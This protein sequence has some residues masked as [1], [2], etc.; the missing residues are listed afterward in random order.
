MIAIESKQL[1][2]KHRFQI[3][4]IIVCII[5]IVFV[6]Y[7]FL[8]TSI[9][10]N[11][12][13]ANFN[14]PSLK[15][16]NSNTI[17]SKKINTILLNDS[18]RKESSQTVPNSITK[19]KI[20][21]KK[22]KGKIK[23][24]PKPSF[25]ESKKN[26]V[27]EIKRNIISYLYPLS[28]AV[29]VNELPP[30][31][32]GMINVTDNKMGYTIQS[33]NTN[34]KVISI[35][36][37]KEEIPDG[38]TI[39]DVH[40]YF[41]S[42]A[43]KHWN[44][45]KRDSLD[46]ANNIVYSTN[47]E[48]G[49]YINAIIKAPES[50][51][52]QGYTPTSMNDIKV[53]DPASMIQ[54][55]QP[56]IQNNH[57][58]ANISFHIETPKGR[59]GIEPNLDLLY[60]S[61]GGNGI[62]GEGWNLGGI[63]TITVETR[64]GVPQY[65][66][67]FETETYSLDG[68]MLAMADANDNLTMSHRTLNIARINGT[69]RFYCRR[70]SDFSKI[71]RLG[72]LNN[73]IWVVTDKN[74]IKYYYG[75]TTSSGNG[76]VVDAVL[77]EGNKIAEW[78]LRKVEDL[79]QN[80]I[81]YFYDA[82]EENINGNFIKTN[83]LSKIQY[84]FYQNSKHLKN[85]Y[86]LN[87]KYDENVERRKD[88]T[89]NA[90]YGFL[91]SG[92][93][94]LLD[95]IKVSS[96]NYGSD[97]ELE[98]APLEIRKYSFNYSYGSYNKIILDSIRQF[99]YAGNTEQ[100]F[101][102]QKFNY[103][104]IDSLKGK[105]FTD[106]NVPIPSKSFLGESITK[107]KLGFGGAVGIGLPDFQ[108]YSKSLSVDAQ[109]SYKENESETQVSFI[110]V[111]GDNKPDIVRK[112]AGA[113]IYQPNM[114]SFDK[115]SFGAEQPIIGLNSFSKDDGSSYGAGV[116]INGPTQSRVYGGYDQNKTNSYSKY[117]FTDANGDG[118]I[119]VVDNGEVRF[120]TYKGQSSQIEFQKSSANTKSPITTG[121]A[122]GNSLV[123][124]D[125]GRIA[126]EL[127][128]NITI[129]P[130]HDIAKVWIAPDTGTIKIEAPV[131][132]VQPVILPENQEDSIRFKKADGVWVS[133][134][135]NNGNIINP[136]K[137][138][139]NDFS[140]KPINN[141]TTRVNQGDKILFRVQS[142]N[143]E[144]D[145]G[146]F[147]QVV[148]NPTITYTSK[149]SDRHFI[150][151]FDK[152]Q[153]DFNALTDYLNTNGTFN[154]P[155]SGN[156]TILG[157][158]IKPKTKD[159]ITLKIR[160]NGTKVRDSFPDQL[161]VKREASADTVIN[162]MNYRYSSFDS[163][164]SRTL[165]TSKQ[166]LSTNFLVP[167]NYLYN[168]T[169]FFEITPAS[170]FNL[171]EIKWEPKI[172]YNHYDT[173]ETDI[174]KRWKKDS[175]ICSP[176]INFKGRLI[177]PG[178][179]I[180]VKDSGEVKI[181]PVVTLRS[182][183]NAKVNLII[184]DKDKIIIKK[185]ISKST[186]LKDTIS[187]ARDKNDFFTVSYE[188]ESIN[189]IDTSIVSGKTPSYLLIPNDFK[190]WVVP[191]TGIYNFYSIQ[192]GALAKSILQKNGI[193]SLPH[194]RDTLENVFL[195]ENDIISFIDTINRINIMPFSTIMTQA[196]AIFSNWEI[197]DYGSLYRGWGQGVFNASNHLK[198]PIDISLF[199]LEQIQK[200]NFY[201][202][203]FFSMPQNGKNLHYTGINEKVFINRDTMSS[204]RLAMANVNPDPLFIVNT[205][206]NAS[207]AIAVVKYS[208]SESKSLAFGAGGVTANQSLNGTSVSYSDYID[209]N[210]DRH[211]DIIGQSF[212]Q[213]TTPL[214][215]LQANSTPMSTGLQKSSSNSF[216]INLG[217]VFFHPFLAGGKSGNQNVNNVST[218]SSKIASALSGFSGGY[219]NN[220]DNIESNLY[221]ING[222]GLPDKVNGN[223]NVYL[224]IGNG[225]S[226]QPINWGLNG[227]QSSTSNTISLGGGFN[228]DNNSISGGVNIAESKTEQNSSLIDF[229][230]DGLI[231][232][233]V[234]NGNDLNFYLNFGAAINTNNNQKIKLENDFKIGNSLATSRG[235]SG[236]YTFSP[237]IFAILVPVCKIVFSVS[238]NI[239]D[240][241][242][243][244]KSQWTDING[245]GFIDY[246]TYGDNSVNIKLS[247]LGKINRLKD[248]TG[249]LGGSFEIDYKH[250]KADFNHPGG[251]WVM[252]SLVTDD[253]INIDGSN[254]KSTFEYSNGNYE[255][256]EREFLGF[257]KIETIDYLNNEPYR[258]SIK[259]YNNDNY[260]VTNQLSKKW[261]EDTIGRKYDYEEYEY[262]SK[263]RTKANQ[264]NVTIPTPAS[265][266]KVVVMQSPIK[267]KKEFTYEGKQNKLL[268]NQ[269][270][271]KYDSLINVSSYTFKEGSTPNQQDKTFY[272]SDI[273]FKSIDRARNI[274]GLP[275]L[276]IVKNK[277]GKVLKKVKANYPFTLPGTSGTVK[278]YRNKMQSDTVFFTDNR[279][280]VTLYEYD[281][282]CGNLTKKTYA[283]GKF[284][285]YEYDGTFQTYLTRITDPYKLENSFKYDYRF[286]F[287]IEKILTNG[288]ATK[289][290]YD[291]FGR[292]TKIQGPNQTNIDIDNSDFTI[293]IEY[294]PDSKT[295][296]SIIKHYDEMHNDEGIY[297]INFVDGFNKN[298]QIK[299]TGVINGTKQWIVSGRQYYDELYRV[300]K[301]YYSTNQDYDVLGDMIIGNAGRTI[302]SDTDKIAATVSNYDIVDRL[303]TTKLPNSKIFESNSYSIK[304]DGFNNE[305][306]VTTTTYTDN[307]NLN[308]KEVFTNGSGLIS[309]E[310]YYQEATNDKIKKITKYHYDPIH[311]LDSVFNVGA[312]MDFLVIANQYDWA[313]R[314][315]Q[316]YN[317]SSGV[318]RYEYDKLNNLERKISAKNDTINYDYDHK[319]II[320]IQYPKH[321]EDS[322]RYVY[323]ERMNPESYNNAG[324]VVFQIDATGAQ[325]FTY[326]VFGNIATNIRTIIA[327]FDTT[328]T[329]ATKYKYDS[330]GR[331]QQMIYPG[332][333]AVN[334]QYNI[335]GSLLK[336]FGCKYG[337][338]VNDFPY[339][340]DVTYDKFEQRK[341][342]EYGNGLTSIY[343]YED[344][345]RRLSIVQTKKGNSELMLSTYKYDDLN[346]V[347]EN[348]NK[349]GFPE[350]PQ[351]NTSHN[352]TYD[353]QNQ[354]LNASGNW[355][356]TNKYSLSLTYNAQF[357][358]NTKSLN[359][360]SQTIKRNVNSTYSY[361]TNNPLQ[362]NSIQDLV[363]RSNT[364]TGTNYKEKNTAYH[365]YDPSGNDIVT[366]VADSFQENVNERK[367]LWD[368]E[369][370]IRA[371]STNGYVSSY[372]YDANGERTIKLSNEIEGV[373]VNGLFA[374]NYT[375]TATY[376]M[377]VNP[378]FSVR[379]ARGIG[380]KHIYI[381]KE[382]IVSQLTD[383]S[384]WSTV[385]DDVSIRKPEQ[386]T[387]KLTVALV[388]INK[389]IP[390]LYI[391]KMY[392]T[393]ALMNSYLDSLQVP[394]KIIE[395]NA[396]KKVWP[397]LNYSV[398]TDP[399][400]QYD[401]GKAISLVDVNEK[402]RYY[403]HSNYLGSASFI[404]DK[405]A[406]IVQYVEYLPF[407][408]TF[409]EQRKNYSSQFL[410]NGKEQDQE[411]GLYYYSA[412]YY[413][414]NTYQWLGVDPMAEKYAG[415]S[416][417]N[418][419][420]NS[421]L[422]LMDS[423]GKE[424]DEVSKIPISTNN[425]FG[426]AYGH[427]RL[428]S[429][430][431]LHIKTDQLNFSGITKENIETN[432]KT[433]ELSLQTFSGGINSTSL[434]LGKIGLISKGGNNYEIKND[435][436][437]FNIELNNLF[438]GKD[439]P[440][441]IFTALGG[442]FHNM[443]DDHIA[444]PELNKTPKPFN[445]YF[446]GTI[447][448]PPAS[449]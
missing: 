255:R 67:N 8:V 286:G 184:S 392:K 412:R 428:G 327:P 179:Y 150:D 323:G 176:K 204:S 238:A 9:N 284:E 387:V 414:P 42:K 276:L 361:K 298:I 374:A 410:F 12:F 163:V 90:R 89:F 244:V 406:A 183:N 38:Y 334:Y 188:I 82:K 139:A 341:S 236:S 36:F 201:E 169:L 363:S 272:K 377:F 110:D 338:N 26:K 261:T 317:I 256:Y 375:N 297:T 177:K 56:P 157:Q 11:S 423:D 379:N 156:Y 152:N 330:W 37:S 229:N 407:G 124:E 267:N 40:T 50:P 353:N 174:G 440:R 69:R 382:R 93:S 288:S 295:P 16:D 108:F 342:I 233:V 30:L 438:S 98:E 154:L 390:V 187:F 264:T 279:F 191:Q 315:K 151:P 357:N 115:I 75:G 195:K 114:S 74:G 140:I 85:L 132:L 283:N 199:R 417:Y 13:A 68:K 226:S 391:K 431:D 186:F 234:K 239:G 383:Y 225:F 84:T 10:K 227:I 299:K 356:N 22:L 289:T 107:A 310:V 439:I 441:N 394:H 257:E 265:M 142:G 167:K 51:E 358:I 269:T 329:F 321:P 86:E 242:N 249:P 307:I 172:I 223:G 190:N 202:T 168:T 164:Y 331:L 260:F 349:S 126:T 418:F 194:N 138:S 129:S 237:H 413:D 39:G 203:Q 100:F 120:N 99:G 214:G 324:K 122:I 41:Y 393:E 161:I 208:K 125:A 402:L 371:I 15:G 185:E 240:G 360:V 364:V 180:K 448:I 49:D 29:S 198:R 424:P 211:P 207:G 219:N 399:A 147:D 445:I 206:I 270:E 273:I 77:R 314:K 344:T 328:Y 35:K 245:D 228:S 113:M 43:T 143:L 425:L 308:K 59:Q 294:E 322:V 369:N 340:N 73:Y 58:S 246:V 158:F 215:G 210:G 231:D 389:Y 266:L 133:I 171:T 145:N 146:D 2:S 277:E 426:T 155:D 386:D 254:S 200:R 189:D 280:A 170:S 449:K 193:D 159:S 401:V 318:I 205:A 79:F 218:A 339:V 370:R 368:E 443:P 381:G 404:S 432:K 62:L 304:N 116:E 359:L 127:R 121:G 71:E 336:V 250:N 380:T 312:N 7:T 366:N 175:I 72:S 319:R 181:S 301:S 444:T 135:Q 388:P 302:K 3:P 47:S 165:D 293:K 141:I 83:F 296:Y 291:N 230:G 1:L 378:Y 248:I 303:I 130:F 23:L 109:F 354:L 305:A 313:G 435:K 65:N 44:Q 274:Y 87:F 63:S 420:L 300:K 136:L 268:L 24:D 222:D 212:I 57:G 128:N 285:S 25:E 419:C 192:K 421:P 232:R 4:F 162:F 5:T 118:L 278:N 427:Y 398:V 6:Y 397:A 148:W 123:Q 221:D 403:Y 262:Y 442:I 346:N 385:N 178:I 429:G 137:I 422:R 306:R 224:N 53:G 352:Y 271:Y 436:Y 134:Q 281:D 411:T 333:E 92:N 91:S 241:S 405:D 103:Y 372:T 104:S 259:E 309:T 408:E 345:L 367:I 430:D 55:I 252:S 395:H 243:V 335:A 217:G 347:K 373:Y 149:N 102:S 415:L 376:S 60:N 27:N 409:M 235:I 350:M 48:D 119:D 173:T 96:V 117:Y 80:S 316:Y 343:S 19:N 433:G 216:G 447:T 292:I 18:I 112:R 209:L 14:L 160:I 182:N 437:D 446:H 332:G 61:D 365:N 213:Y 17:K 384:T 166:N 66:T 52:T 263:I 94:K 197:Q 311:Q 416:P 33:N 31:E 105:Y 46:V 131:Q 253:G 258:K 28:N 88:F 111:N 275:T 76:N 362:L 81:E 400:N 220:N 247:N 287:D 54:I 396:F 348:I 78:K 97:G 355:N 320:R 290:K 45:L 251:K 325:S 434:A 70:E 326:D 153:F 337:T 282:N 64:W 144:T 20:T 21:E 351:V 95:F 196:S 101:Y 106:V 34:P 32:N